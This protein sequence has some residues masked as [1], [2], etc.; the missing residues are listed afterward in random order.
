MPTAGP[1]NP[2]RRLPP[3]PSL[4]QLRKQAKDLLDGYRASNPTAVAEVHRFERHPDPAAF[5]LHDAQRV[6]ARAYGYVSWARLKACVDGANVARLAEAVQRGDET[7]ARALLR[8]RPELARMD[9]AGDNEHQA[10]HYAVLRRDGAMVRLLTAAGADARKGIFPHRDATTAFALARDR[11]YG[12][13]VA[14]IEEEERH[15]REAIELPQR[16][17]FAGTGP[18]RLRHTQPRQCRSDPAH[19]GR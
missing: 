11:G 9:M 18:N 15:R 7:Q 19:G 4:E 12:D 3:Q 16:H 13:I 6:L 14:A 1:P 8:S 17:G 5:A 10:L 2:L